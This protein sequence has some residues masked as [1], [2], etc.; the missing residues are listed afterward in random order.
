MKI[1]GKYTTQGTRERVFALLLDED[2]LRRCVPGCRRLVREG[3]DRFAVTLDVGLG[4][5]QGT[6]EGTVSFRQKV[7]PERLE[8][9]ID[10]KGKL[11]F[12]RGTA[13]LQLGPGDNAIQSTLITYQA[14][15]Q[16]G[17]TIAGVGQRMIQ[18][19]AKMMAGQ[20]FAAIEAEAKAAATESAVAVKHGRL[21]NL[22]RW[23]R[24]ILRNLFRRPARTA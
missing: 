2:M 1:E 21:R 24:S 16:I 3:D 13:S 12:V 11:G 8:M 5:V 14:E 17:G 18:G 10:G 7:P 20:F 6:Y 23:L 22:L 9:I 19:A 4:S 15:V